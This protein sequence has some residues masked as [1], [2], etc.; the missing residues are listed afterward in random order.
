MLLLTAQLSDASWDCND[1]PAASDI[2]RTML[3]EVRS[4]DCELRTVNRGRPWWGSVHRKGQKVSFDLD[5]DL[6][7]GRMLIC[8]SSM[9]GLGLK[10]WRG[11]SLDE[12]LVI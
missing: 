4:G 9:S 8:E 3:D 1:A 12:Y 5:S 10:L 2:L 7:A 11:K 6:S